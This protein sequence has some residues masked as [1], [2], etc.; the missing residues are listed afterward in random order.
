[1]LFLEVAPIHIGTHTMTGGG[2]FNRIELNAA[3]PHKKS[4]GA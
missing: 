2:R 3:A 1:M 4:K